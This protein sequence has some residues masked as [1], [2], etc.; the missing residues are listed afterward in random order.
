[1][2]ILQSLSVIFIFFLSSAIVKLLQLEE[3]YN[4][5]TKNQC[6]R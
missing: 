3:S 5:A 4:Q 1:M 6:M 2:P